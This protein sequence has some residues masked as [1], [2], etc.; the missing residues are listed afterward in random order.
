[1]LQRK[2]GFKNF[3]FVY[4]NNSVEIF[5]QLAAT[6]FSYFKSQLVPLIFGDKSAHISH[7]LIGIKV[8]KTIFEKQS[9]FIKYANNP[10]NS[11]ANE[12]LDLLLEEL[13]KRIIEAL[14]VGASYSG[15]NV[16][17]T[18]SEKLNPIPRYSISEFPI[19]QI[20]VEEFIL[21]PNI[22]TLKYNH[23]FYDLENY[24]LLITY[25]R[26]KI[27][28]AVQRWC[29]FTRSSSEQLLDIKSIEL[30]KQFS[31]KV[32]DVIYQ[33]CCDSNLILNSNSNVSNAPYL[34]ALSNIQLLSQTSAYDRE[35]ITRRVASVFTVGVKQSSSVQTTGD[36]LE[37]EK[38]PIDLLIEAI[39]ALTITLPKKTN[40]FLDTQIFVAQYLVHP[41]A[42]LSET[43][44]LT[45]Q[46][47]MRNYPET[48]SELIQGMI[49]LLLKYNDNNTATLET[50]L[51]HLVLLLD[52]W[53]FLNYQEKITSPHETKSSNSRSGKRLAGQ[54][55]INLK[56]SVD[57]VIEAEAV[58][59]LNLCHPNPRIRLLSLQLAHSLYAVSDYSPNSLSNILF[60]MGETI[61][62]KA[63]YRY[64]LNLSHGFPQKVTIPKDSPI[65]TIEAIALSDNQYLWC[66]T[67]T[68]ICKNC[69]TM[70]I[71][72]I[73]FFRNLLIQRILSLTSIQNSY[74]L[75]PSSTHFY[76]T[77]LGYIALAGSGSESKLNATSSENE[78]NLLLNE[79]ITKRLNYHTALFSTIGSIGAIEKYEQQEKQFWEYVNQ[80]WNNLT[81]PPYASNVENDFSILIFE[82]L[83]VSIGS[84]TP[85][86]I[87]RVLHSFSTWYKDSQ[88]SKKQKLKLRAHLVHLFRHL[89]QEDSFSHVIKIGTNFLL[90]IECDKII[91]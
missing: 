42:Q 12:D 44:S 47:I 29:E 35:D 7:K 33:W 84:V 8:L 65:P 57:T 26:L 27:F 22:N 77:S 15:I 87:S 11:I 55:L 71:K 13:Q 68:E 49:S 50:L 59:L 64:L 61:V 86:G 10:S 16:A 1:M 80:Y 73:P 67:L 85:N 32:N 9:Q 51:S 52:F 25:H 48:R 3:N 54:V 4:V 82:E 40:F 18:S 31:K 36:S 5:V 90:F 74:K 56:P 63:R 46:S 21:P 58:I 24:E 45:L 69:T 72:S 91:I 78:N 70:N 34:S 14:E 88:F 83:F 6:N 20:N 43:T 17:G 60:T 66:Y 76:P 23:H 30:E 28:D 41:D 89:S 19:P 38:F 2:G 81:T 53:N 62:Q 79:L 37:N 75:F 39:G